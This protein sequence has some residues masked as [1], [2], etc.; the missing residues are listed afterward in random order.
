M[1]LPNILFILTDDLG[2]AD[3][4]CYGSSFYETPNLDALAKQSMRFTN[5]YAACPVCSPTRAS[6]LTGKYPATVGIT[7]WIDWTGGVHPC[8]GRLVDVPYL[9][10]LPNSETILAAALSEGGYATWHVGKWH[11]GGEGASPQDHGFDVNIGGCHMGDPGAGGYFSPW[12]IPALADVD[13]PDGTYLTDYLTD[14]AI[15]LVSKHEDGPFFL[16]LWYYTVHT[17]IEAKADKIAKYE[18]RARAM[19]LDKVQAC[20]VGDKFPTENTADDRILRRVVQSD[21]V[22]AAMIESLDENI[23]RLLAAI[24]TAGQLENT[25]VIFTSDNGG[26]AT[27]AGSPTCNAPLAEG[28]G[29]MYEGGTR[30]PLLIKWP[31]IIPAG[32]MCSTPI[33]SPDFYPTLLQAAELALM[34]DQHCDGVSF[35]ALL[36]GDENF[37][38]GPI[39]WH[40]PHYGNQGG[41]PGSSV[42]LGDYK[43]IEFFEEDRVELYN[44]RVD[45]G[46]KTN[47]AEAEP[48]RTAHMKQ[49]LAEWRLSVEAKIPQSNPD[50]EE[51]RATS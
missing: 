27:A 1:S 28:K 40:Y 15:D 20:V 25:L 17:P 44:L 5:A 13:I 48:D 4:G 37:E 10:N 43:L 34:P 23:G 33:T 19:G 21:P 47:L 7:D 26:L 42:R 35:L 31:G 9:K 12:T 6:I 3:L 36:Q 22:Y 49:L 45:L 16:N 8:R 39:F 46:E 50:W 38:R 18:A 51:L 32:S 29:W 24:D 41:T 14:Q 11:L 30:E 2:W